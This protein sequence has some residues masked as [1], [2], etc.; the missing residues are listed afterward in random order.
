MISAETKSILDII[1]KS[2][3]EWKAMYM[4][5]WNYAHVVD[6][7]YIK[8]KINLETAGFIN[9]TSGTSVALGYMAGKDKIPLMLEASKK[10]FYGYKPEELYSILT[11][12]DTEFTLG[13]LI[14][15]FSLVEDL[16]LSI[17]LVD[18]RKD[19]GIDEFFGKSLYNKIL[20]AG[21]REELKLAKETRNSFTHR[22]CKIED[23]WL[24]AYSN[25]R[26]S[27]PTALMGRNLIQGLPNLFHEIETWHDLIVDISKRIE[28]AIQK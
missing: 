11:S 6:R 12:K 19:S 24:N 1:K 17:E 18:T 13:H 2:E 8:G 25:A 3:D 7:E 4:A 15:L 14:T 9:L 23:K 21:E 5:V 22:G 26:G 27:R 20:K 16:F 28:K 10:G